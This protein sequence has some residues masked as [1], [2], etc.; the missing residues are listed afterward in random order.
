MTRR[1]TISNVTAAELARVISALAANLPP[2]AEIKPRPAGGALCAYAIDTGELAFPNLPCRGHRIACRRTGV[3]TFAANC[4][5]DKCNCFEDKE[6][7][8]ERLLLQP[9]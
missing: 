5:R 4:R 3:V 1:E 7:L 6:T 2:P 9:R 8:N